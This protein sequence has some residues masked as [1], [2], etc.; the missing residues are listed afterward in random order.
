MDL[1]QKIKIEVDKEEGYK[2]DL[3]VSNVKAIQKHWFREIRLFLD[4]YYELDYNLN[5][6]DVFAFHN[7][8]NNHEVPMYQIYIL[9]SQKNKY[10]FFK[11]KP[12]IIARIRLVGLFFKNKIPIFE[13]TCSESMIAFRLLKEAGFQVE[14]KDYTKSSTE[15]FISNV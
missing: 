6:D 9:K 3:F 7:P 11:Q 12:I 15:E 5:L 14:L 13:A 4:S 10:I 1:M 2:P 8:Y